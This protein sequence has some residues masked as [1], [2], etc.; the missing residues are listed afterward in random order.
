MRELKIVFFKTCL[1]YLSVLMVVGF[2]A[3]GTILKRI[4]Y[5]D[6]KN[7]EMP[8]MTFSWFDTNSSPTYELIWFYQS[9]WRTFYAMIVS[10]IDSLIAGILAHISTKCR[11]LQNSIKNVV[12][13]ADISSVSNHS[14][15]IKYDSNF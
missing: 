6:S 9:W 11:I 3:L 10:S 7:W 1:Y 12:A 2:G 13:D 8:F 14:Y 5:N 4:V 15:R